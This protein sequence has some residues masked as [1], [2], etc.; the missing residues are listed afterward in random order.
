MVC[1]GKSPGLAGS[2]VGDGT[3]WRS[4]EELSQDVLRRSLEELSQQWR[5]VHKRLRGMVNIAADGRR[6]GCAAGGRAFIASCL[7]TKTQKQ[8][9]ARWRDYLQPSLV[10]SPWTG[11]EHKR[12]IE[13]QARS[14]N[15]PP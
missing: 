8:V 10:S 3:T 14:A 6:P 2:N 7:G 12:M 5:I 9:Y 13:L 15:P 4:L 1:G 11:D